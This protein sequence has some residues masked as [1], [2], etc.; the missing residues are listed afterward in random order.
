MDEASV[1]TYEAKSRRRGHWRPGEDKNLRQLMEQY[2]P[3]NWNF[4]AEKLQGRSG[5]SCR[6][7]W[8]NHLDP[9]LNRRPFSEEEEERLLNAHSVHGNKWAL[10]SAASVGREGLTTSSAALGTS[11]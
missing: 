9:T 2:S 1:G 3:Q 6:F 4:I 10:S 7:R 11:P 5:K 8:I